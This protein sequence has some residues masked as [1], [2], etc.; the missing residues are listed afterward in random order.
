MGP[1]K[2]RMKSAEMVFPSWQP[3][4][5]H[6]G[7]GTINRIGEVINGYSD[8]VLVIT[9]KGSVQKSGFLNKIKTMLSST[10]IRYKICQGVE[11]NPSKETV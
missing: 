8:R 2:D 11:P 9:G 3:T 7:E 4:K 6:F 5:V 10:G 1:V